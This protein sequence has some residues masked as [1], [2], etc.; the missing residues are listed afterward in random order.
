MGGIKVN[1][2]RKGGSKFYRK[3]GEDN[4]TIMA[5][6]RYEKEIAELEIKRAAAND[7]EDWSARNWCDAQLY[8][9]R[10]NLQVLKEKVKKIYY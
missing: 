2:R 9:K 7:A 5:I 4:P 6:R 8:A 10:G 3:F 1:P